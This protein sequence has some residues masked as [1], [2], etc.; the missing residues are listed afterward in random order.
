[1][2]IKNGSK[3]T[4]PNFVA[5]ATEFQE[6]P[7]YVENSPIE[8]VVA[9]SPVVE[10]LTS[11]MAEMPMRVSELS[12]EITQTQKK[13]NTHMENA[14]KSTE[15]L[16][17]FSQGNFEALIKSSQIWATGLQDLG[18]QFAA[19]AQAQMDE[20]L[21]SVKSL[22]SVKSLKEALDLQTGMAKAAMEKIVA[23]TGKVTD[24]TVKLAEQTLAPITARVTLATEKFG[25]AA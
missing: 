23:E 1:M 13:V 2:A 17:S 25:R 8:D 6:L 16:V 3:I 19:T 20:T 10:A 18:R 11:T 21:A 4:Q 9:V 7:A 15:E 5:N 14:I 22:S 12:T 24:A